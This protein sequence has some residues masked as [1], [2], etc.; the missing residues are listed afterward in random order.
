MD[1]PD[2]AKPCMS[3]HYHNPWA[4]TTCERCDK[5]L[6]AFGNREQLREDATAR[7]KVTRRRN[8]AREDTHA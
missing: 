2:P 6:G 3:C 8:K 4:R 1:T 5:P 7:A